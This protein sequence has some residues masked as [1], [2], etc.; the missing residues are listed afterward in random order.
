MCFLRAPLFYLFFFLFILFVRLFIYFQCRVIYKLIII[1]IIMMMMIIDKFDDNFLIVLYGIYRE[2][3]LFN[4]KVVFL[5]VM[6]SKRK[7]RW[8]NLLTQPSILK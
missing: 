4:L 6:C 1:I 2:G 3:K 8:T 7:K 5:F